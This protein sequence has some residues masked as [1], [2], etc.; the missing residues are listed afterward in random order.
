[1]TRN[2]WNQQE[3]TEIGR[4]AIGSRTRKKVRER[5]ILAETAGRTQKELNRR[6]RLTKRKL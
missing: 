5:K 1:V 4:K 2:D 3:V 6:N